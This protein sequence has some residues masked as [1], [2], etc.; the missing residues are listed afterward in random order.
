MTRRSCSWTSRPSAWI[1]WARASARQTV[2][3]L[4][5][6]GKTVLLTT[7][8]MFEADALCDRIAVINAGRIV[9][10][11]TGDDLKRGVANRT[12]V[13]IETFGVLPM[14][15]AAAGPRR[16]RGQHRGA[17]RARSCWS[18]ASMAWPSPSACWRCWANCG[19][20]S[21]HPRADARGRVRRPIA[22]TS[23]TDD[24]AR[25]AVARLTE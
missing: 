16:D 6:A 9:A 14:R 19:S 8:Y 22:S 24:A 11:G 1:R 12:I 5:D 17:T 15:S 21:G 10:I 23:E 4:V 7:H 2:Q 13:E 25:A 3:S 18:R 20:A